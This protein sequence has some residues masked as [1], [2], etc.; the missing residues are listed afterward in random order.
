M[1]IVVIYHVFCWVHN[2]L[3]RLNVGFIGVDLFLY[4]SGF[5]LAGSYKKDSSSYLKRR[6]LRIVPLYIITSLIIIVINRNTDPFDIFY[7]LTTISYYIDPQWSIDWYL[8]SIF[9]L[10]LSLPLIYKLV[11]KYNIVVFWVLLL[12]SIITFILIDDIHWKY[13]CLISRIPIFCLG[14][15]SYL[16][17]VSLKKLSI[18]LCI[19]CIPLY[20]LSIFL[21]MSMLSIPLLLLI[22]KIHKKYDS[23]IIRYIGDNSLEIYC[24]NQIVYYVL[25]HIDNIY[26]KPITYILVQLI[27][28]ILLIKINSVI[29]T[30]IAGIKKETCP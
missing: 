10:Y 26:F 23:S 30:N 29:K 24:A 28:S 1:I 14:I 4:I 17:K 20:S 3:G 22:N 2:P 7:K 19:L 25:L 9:I 5:C 6:V 16:H 27:A 12:L 21:S 15:T 13:D 18:G 11:E 8:N